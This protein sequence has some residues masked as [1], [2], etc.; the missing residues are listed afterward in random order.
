MRIAKPYIR[1]FKGIPVYIS[2]PVIYRTK[3]PMIKTFA[4]EIKAEVNGQIRLRRS[5]AKQVLELDSFI[6]MIKIVDDMAKKESLK[7]VMASERNLVN[8]M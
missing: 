3:Y 8:Q 2:Y 6:D 1:E 5:T 7:K 4:I